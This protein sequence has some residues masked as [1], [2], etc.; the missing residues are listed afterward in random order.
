M[1]FHPTYS[2]FC[3]AN[4]GTLLRTGPGELH[5]GIATSTAPVGSPETITFYDNT[6]DSGNVLLTLKLNENSPIFIQLRSDMPLRFST[7]LTVVTP[8]SSTCH[9]TLFY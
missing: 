2:Q 6:L 3:P 7:D 4:T 8:A 5:D 9:V 1:K